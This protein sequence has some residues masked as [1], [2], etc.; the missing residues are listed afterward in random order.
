MVILDIQERRKKM[1]CNKF[2]CAVLEYLG[3]PCVA[4]DMVFALQDCI[5]NGFHIVDIRQNGL[6]RHAGQET[7]SRSKTK[8]E[9]CPELNVCLKIIWIFSAW[10]LYWVLTHLTRGC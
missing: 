4:T 1:C 6:L 10:I 2:S 3:S 5:H 8:F 7:K 9:N